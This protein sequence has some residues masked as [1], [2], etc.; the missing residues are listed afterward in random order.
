MLL[1]ECF[2]LLCILT[3]R[4]G[5]CV[6]LVDLEQKIFVVLGSSLE[7]LKALRVGRELRILKVGREFR[8]IINQGRSRIQDSQVRLR[9]Q[10]SQGSLR[11][12]DNQGRSSTHES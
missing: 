1:R 11:T 12:Q 4:Y 5:L 10:D 8:I 7:F 9:T 2:L 6:L 3:L